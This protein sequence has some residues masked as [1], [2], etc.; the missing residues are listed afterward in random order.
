[1]SALRRLGKVGALFLVLAL[2]AGSALYLTDPVFYQRYVTA[3]KALDVAAVDW[4]QPAQTVPGGDARLPEGDPDAID[5]SAVDAA[6]EYAEAK[7]SHALLVLHQ[8]ERVIEE[9]WGGHGPQSP[10]DSSSMHKSVLG[11]LLGAAIDDGL[12]E[13]IDDPV[14]AYIEEW[15]DGDPRGEITL[16]ELASMQS[17]LRLEALGFAPWSKG[18]RLMLG[19]DVDGTALALPL[20]E[21]PGEAFV[22]QNFNAQILG[23]ALSR[24]VDQPY[25]EYLSQRLWQPL[26]AP[27]A[28]VWLD[29]EGGSPRTFCCLMTTA[30]AWAHVGALVLN[31]GAVGEEQLVPSA[32][33]EEMARPSGANPNYGLLLWRGAPEDGVRTYNPEAG[34][35]AHHSE[36]YL[37][38][39]VVFFD[40]AGGQRVYIIPS[41]EMVIVR[42]GE[43]VT[44]WDDAVLPNTL[45]RGL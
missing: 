37:A 27:E 19:T 2:L 25:A 40:G 24:V 35:E 7:D 15:G 18:L 29:R 14:G 44:D 45:L 36:P 5:A 22:Y 8:G 13:S 28:A 32:W 9:Y 6:L 41:A 30:R 10:F 39:D 23:I 1:M 16:R 34:F 33:V 31:E 20:E 21:P 38:P 17:G 43:A 3:M 11:L 4:R 12:I 26:G 42:I